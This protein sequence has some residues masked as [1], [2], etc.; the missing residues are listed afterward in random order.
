[1]KKIF[2]IFIILIYTNQVEAQ[3]FG[4]FPYF[5]SYMAGVIPPDIIIPTNSGANDA[6]FIFDV[7]LELTRPN[8]N[9]FGS[10]VVDGRQFSAVN[11][12]N[13]EFEFSMSGGDGINGADGI[14]FFLFDANVTPS[15]GGRGGALGYRY[16]RANNNFSGSRFPGLNG[17]YL[18]IGLDGFGNFKNSYFT[19][20]ARANGVQII[21]GLTQNDQVTLRGAMGPDLSS[22]H[23][24]MGLRFT[25]YP[26]LITRTTNETG[27]NPSGVILDPEVGNF[28][29]LPPSNTSFNLRT[30]TVQWSPSQPNYRKAYIS[31][32]PNEAGGFNITIKIQHGTIISTIID[33]YWYRNSLMYFENARSSNNSDFNTSNIIG[34]ASSH[35]LDAT[36]PEFL[37]FGLV[38]TTGGLNNRHIIRNFKAT[39]PFSAE[40]VNDEIIVC[41]N[42]NAILFPLEND[43]AYEGPIF[44]PPSGSTSNIDLNSFRFLDVNR[45]PQSNPYITPQGTW[46]YNNVNGQVLFTPDSSFTT[47]QVNVFYD[48][49][50]LT[51][52]F[53]DDAYRNEPASIILNY[54]DIGC[55]KDCIITNSTNSIK[56]K[57]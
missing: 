15:V 23:G 21:N 45:V 37:K 12:I 44:G 1:M 3:L 30:S 6:K 43:N 32:L 28:L 48:F 51:F 16:N 5:D 19:Q 26:V 17:A 14:C 47:G 13:F 4:D 8:N 46:T 24:G 39:L 35:I 38:A 52:P 10:V 18:G 2:K 36:V 57:Q 31:L 9:L 20:N 22:I 27:M 50:G 25:G 55:V 54:T 53:S 11:G 7:G 33:N 49:K 40:G 29:F 42:K 34:P 56:L 41:E